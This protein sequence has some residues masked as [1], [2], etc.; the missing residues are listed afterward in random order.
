MGCAFG[1]SNGLEPFTS[2]NPNPKHWV[3]LEG[4]NLPWAHVLKIKYLDCTNFEG[5]KILVYEGAYVHRADR[6]PHFFEDSDPKIMARFHPH[7]WTLACN[8]AG[9]L[10]EL[11]LADN[12][13]TPK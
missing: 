12:Q 6:D 7:E 13:T 5:V 4:F 8:F 3:L 11:R 10:K 1:F 2:K 9:L